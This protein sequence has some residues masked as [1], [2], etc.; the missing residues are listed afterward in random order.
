MDAE[1]REG[2]RHGDENPRGGE[3]HEKSSLASLKPWLRRGG[4]ARRSEPE[5]MP[6]IRSYVYQVKRVVFEAV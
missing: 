6:R 1:W 5:R 4:A 2:A 3:H